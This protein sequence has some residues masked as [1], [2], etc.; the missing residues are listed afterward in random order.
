MIEDRPGVYIWTIYPAR[1]VYALP[2]G[3]AF[4]SRVITPEKISYRA[5]ARVFTVQDRRDMLQDI[6]PRVCLPGRVSCLVAC[7]G[8]DT[9]GPIGYAGP[10][11]G[12]ATR[13]RVCFPGPVP[14]Y[15]LP[16]GA[17]TIGAC[18]NPG[19]LR[20]DRVTAAGPEPRRDYS[21]AEKVTKRPSKTFVKTFLKNS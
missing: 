13:R 17:C 8:Q 1:R 15:L 2:I 7:P 3:G 14:G 21:R 18:F 12:P 4:L 11:P 10:G 19:P 6:R 9:G 20:R 16:I 5:G